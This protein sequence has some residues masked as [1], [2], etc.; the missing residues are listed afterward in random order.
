MTC[1][2]MNELSKRMMYK[3]WYGHGYTKSRVFDW[4]KAARIIKDKLV[5]H[6]YLIAKAGLR[7]DF[8]CTGGTI[9]EFGEKQYS[10]TFLKSE[11]ATPILELIYE[12]DEHEEFECWK[13]AGCTEWNEYTQ[14]PESADYILKG[15]SNKK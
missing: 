5:H 9:F 11:W 6:P 13:Y 14:W 7:E 2:K 3:A 12:S 1:L 10:Y 8:Y 15:N 4:D